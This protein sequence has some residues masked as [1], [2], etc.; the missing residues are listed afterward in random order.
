MESKGGR[1]LGTAMGPEG[2]PMT[3]N[4]GVGF[5]SKGL[6]NK[7][8]ELLNTKSKFDVNKKIDNNPE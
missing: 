3:S 2:R 6:E 8:N 1:P 7:A 4:K 5:T